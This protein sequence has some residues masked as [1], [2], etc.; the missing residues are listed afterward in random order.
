LE[1]R[2]D[3]GILM[4]GLTGADLSDPPKLHRRFE[5]IIIHEGE[6]KVLVDLSAVPYMNS[7]QIGAV[8]GLHVLAYENLSVVKFVGLHERIQALFKLL[9]V[10]TLLD[11]HYAR[12]KSALESFGVFDPLEG[13]SGAPDAPV[14]AGR[15]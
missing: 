12:A 7:L 13:E 11:M 8:V 9:G 3:R 5:E 1:T 15:E 2:R 10:D 14:D 4:V 6:R